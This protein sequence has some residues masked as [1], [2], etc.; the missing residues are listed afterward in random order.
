M[1]EEG[2]EEC[3]VLWCS[4]MMTGAALEMRGGNEV[5]SDVLTGR[6]RQG[7]GGGGGGKEE[8]ILEVDTDGFLAEQGARDEEEEEVCLELSRG[9]ISH[10]R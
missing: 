1:I 10:P 3:E 5:E 2:E 9:E 8:L 7:R 6:S 4:V